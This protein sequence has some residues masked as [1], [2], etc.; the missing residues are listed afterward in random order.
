VATIFFTEHAK[1]EAQRR[2]IELEM[3]RSLIENQPQK[4]PVKRNRFVLQGKYYDKIENKDMLLRVIIE[5]TGNSIKV[6]SVYRTS[7]I[8]KYWIEG[9]A[10]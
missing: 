7:K 10:V 8:D 4:L 9:D 6:I 1:F 5:P 2:G 3:I